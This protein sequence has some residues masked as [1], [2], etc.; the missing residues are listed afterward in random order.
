MRILYFYDKIDTDGGG[1]YNINMTMIDVSGLEEY[2]ENNRIEAKR[3]AG[4]FPNSLWET[5]SSFANTLGGVIL[6]GVDEHKDRSLHAIDLPDRDGYI[7]IF[8]KTVSDKSKVSAKILTDKDIQKVDFQGKRVLIITVPRAERCDRPVY[9]GGNPYTGTYRRGGEGDYRCTREQV[10]YMLRDAKKVGADMRALRNAR[11]SE[12]DF[13]SV[14]DCRLRLD[15]NSTDPETSR[16]SDLGFLKKTGAAAK[17]RDNN[18]HPTAAG[19]LTFGKRDR[20]LRRFKNFSLSYRD[21]SDGKKDITPDSADAENIYNFFFAVCGRLLEVADGSAVYMALRE[22]LLNCIVNAD[23]T[24]LGGVKVNLYGGGIE[25]I[26]AGSFR[27]N[28]SSA[29]RGGVSDPRNPGIKRLF[30]R[31]GLGSGNGGG[32]PSIYSVWRKKG[33]DMPGFT[34]NFDP[35]YISLNL[36]FSL[37]GDGAPPPVGRGILEALIISYLTEKRTATLEETAK[38]F[39][40]SPNGAKKVMDALISQKLVAADNDGYKLVR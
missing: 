16:L 33:W 5:Y 32:I 28:P 29:A 4:G 34:E 30:K 39:H 40:L 25:F 11:M 18:L 23:Y 6:L 35:D 13:E 24:Q 27:T 37:T 8:N 10:D 21:F 38:D 31:F 12:L 15:M 26:N 2:R 36:K 3:A 22:A 9:I 14:K 7:E 19:L 17:G 1:R 20:I